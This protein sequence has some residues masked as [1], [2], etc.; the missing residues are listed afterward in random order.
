MTCSGMAITSWFNVSFC[1]NRLLYTI[2]LTLLD[3]SSAA[4]SAT[5]VIHA[6][7]NYSGKPRRFP[8][9]LARGP[10][11]TWGFDSGLVSTMEQNS[12]GLWELEIMAIWPTYVQLNVWGFDDYYYGDVDGDGVLDRLPPN[13]NAPNYVNMSA[14]PTPHLSWSLV[15]DDAT[16]QWTLVPRGQSWVGATMYALLLAIPII[17]GTLAVLIFMWSFYGI[18]HNQFGVKAKSSNSYFP[19]L[20]ALGS[21]STSDLKEGGGASEKFF[22]G[23]KHNSEIIGW[24]ED[25]NKRRKVLIATL[26]YEIIDWKVKVKIGGLGVMSS[27]MGKAMTDVD[28]VWV[29]PKVKDVEYPAGDPAEPIEVIIFGEPYLIEVETHVLDNITYVILDS[30]VF[31]AQTKADP[32]PARMDDLSSAIFY[33]TWNQAI[34]ATI[35]RNSTLR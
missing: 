31:R 28:L 29:V 1:N 6:D 13:T 26:E 19:I 16:M 11:N 9:L 22:G 25:K 34:A 12:D 14:P 23:H 27:L 5:A 21:K 30:P 3:W 17:T 8:Q 7:V 32:Y 4:S 35:R 18:R 33:S 10:Y 15:V 20:G 2:S 24:P